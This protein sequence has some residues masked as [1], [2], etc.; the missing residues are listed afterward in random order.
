MVPIWFKRES[1]ISGAVPATVSAD[2]RQKA[3]VR[4]HGK[5]AGRMKHE[6][7]DLPF[8]RQATLSSGVERWERAVSV[9]FHFLDISS[10]LSY[11]KS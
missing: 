10:F 3:T 4:N 7:G 6:P 1:G 2:D 9:I 5:A 8:H 11:F